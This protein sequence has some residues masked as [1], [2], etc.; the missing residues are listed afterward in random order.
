MASLVDSIKNVVGDSHPYFK[1][2]FLSFIIFLII[3]LNSYEFITS[4]IRIFL[5]LLLSVYVIG[6]LVQTI[7]NTLN[8]K[9]VILPN[10]LSVHTI[11]W[12][13]IKS[14]IALL[15][16]GVFGYAL[17][18]YVKTLL[19][20]EPYIN[21]IILTLISVFVIGLLALF[22]LIFGKSMKVSDAY[23]F[24]KILEHSGDF[25]VYSYLLALTS[26]LFL[27]VIFV[28]IGFA[29]NILFGMGLVFEYY[30]IFAAVFV[31]ACVIQYY[32]QMY[33]EFIDLL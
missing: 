3:R 16:V 33:F 13:G 26:A 17:V 4:G 32:C 12:A 6:Y 21:N 15:P 18:M 10:F 11:I 30:I 27:T 31:L 5:I 28:P 25:I 20:F 19:I 8:E 7:F 9:N 24:K 29:V 22:T 2:S 23:N 14:V 1:I